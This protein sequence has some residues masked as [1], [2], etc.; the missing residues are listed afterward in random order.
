MSD[1]PATQAHTLSSEAWRRWEMDSFQSPA[2]AS[3]SG[4]PSREDA[5]QIASRL[6]ALEQQARQRARDQGYAE[7]HA[8]G[9]SAGTA[10]GKEAGYRA[11]YDQGQTEGY[12]KGHAQGYAEG[13]EKA[14]Q[15]AEAITSLASTLAQALDTLE[16][17]LGQ[18]IIALAIGIAEQVV[19][20]TVAARPEALLP[21]VREIVQLHG[22]SDA[23]LII[24]V[25]PDDHKLLQTHLSSD[26]SIKRWRLV[27]DAQIEQG[28][29]RAHTALGA[30][31]ATLATRWRRAVS[32]LGQ[33]P[34]LPS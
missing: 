3:A 13:Q 28:G 11:G 29:C 2:S 18:G 14:R 32:A 34:A 8:E 24:H 16:H 25:H 5:K 7:G 31:D 20:D 26:G 33:S 15:E 19:R 17:D 10:T 4:A 27:P 21:L 12:E 22:D 1:R 23:A 6:K 30:I 9:L